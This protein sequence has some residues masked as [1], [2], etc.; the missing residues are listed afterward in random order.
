MTMMI[1]I[2]AM[3]QKMSHFAAAVKREGQSSS[4]QGCKY[5]PTAAADK[6][7]K[8]NETTHISMKWGKSKAKNKNRSKHF[9]QMEKSTNPPRFSAQYNFQ[10]IHTKGKAA[11][12]S[13]QSKKNLEL[14][15][16]VS[17]KIHHQSISSKHTTSGG[18]GG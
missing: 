3:L 7:T 15:K 13:D 16:N 18:G 10:A 1:I 2:M 9:Q 4:E 8:R 17:I 14:W 12:Y 5:F 11:L 6:R